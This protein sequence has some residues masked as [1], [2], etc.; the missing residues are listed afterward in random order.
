MDNEL[1]LT[2]LIRSYSF[3][4]DGNIELQA[5]RMEFYFDLLMCHN[6]Y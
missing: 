6:G 3:G 5:R 2:L 1:F 4:S